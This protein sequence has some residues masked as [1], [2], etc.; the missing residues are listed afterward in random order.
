ML[1]RVLI[2]VFRYNMIPPLYSDVL[3][4]Q[5]NIILND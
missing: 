3:R 4:V 5:W 1:I 2:F